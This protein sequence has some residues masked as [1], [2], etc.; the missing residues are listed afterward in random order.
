[1]PN[2]IDIDILEVDDGVAIVHLV[3]DAGTITVIAHIYRDG[4]VLAVD[5][6]HVQGLWPGALGPGIWRLAC[7]ILQRLGNVDALRIRGATRTTGRGKGKTPRTVNITWSRC[8]AKGL[9]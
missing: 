9:A 3:T 6:A 5:G 1:M 4:N 7:Q 8:R 2:L